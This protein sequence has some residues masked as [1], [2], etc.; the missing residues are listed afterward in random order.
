[1]TDYQTIETLARRLAAER[2]CDYDRKGAK[3]AYWRREAEAIAKLQ[4][5]AGRNALI[6]VMAIVASLASLAVLWVAL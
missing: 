4:F 3:R 6:G 1:M 2:G 5:D